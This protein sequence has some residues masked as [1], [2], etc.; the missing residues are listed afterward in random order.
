[1]IVEGSKILTREP[2][3]EFVHWLKRF[4]RELNVNL[5]VRWNPQRQRWVIDQQNKDNGLWFCALVWETDDGSYA[6]LNRD[7]ALRL[8]LNAW[9]YTQLIIS[10]HDYILNREREAEA[11]FEQDDRFATDEAI[12]GLMQN[13]KLLRDV[14]DK[15]A[16]KTE[17]LIKAKVINRPEEK[18]LDSE[19]VTEYKQET[20]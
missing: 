7:L 18:S 11:K 10:P 5:R 9:K 13:K 14:S 1:M 3:S 4:G 17:K 15:I 12:Y 2:D 8:Q 20:N 6:D 19:I 16:E